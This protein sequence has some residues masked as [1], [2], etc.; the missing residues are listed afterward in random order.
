[1][2][3]YV[4]A[5]TG[6][7]ITQ[8]Y[9]S[10]WSALKNYHLRKWSRDHRSG[11][12]KGPWFEVNQLCFRI[13]NSESQVQGIFIGA[14][15]AFVVFITIIGPEYA[16]ANPIPPFVCLHLDR[17]H[18]ATFE[19]PRSDFE[20]GGARDKSLRVPRLIIGLSSESE[21]IELEKASV[22]IIDKPD[23]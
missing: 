17:K 16:Y 6:F 7:W 11:L 22:Q 4:S 9:C 10:R 8:Q 3:C 18:G 2:S 15:T 23:T 21:A 19:Q 5:P 13:T 1:M 12:R 14:V 20:K